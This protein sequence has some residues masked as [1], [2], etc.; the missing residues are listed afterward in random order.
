METTDTS[1][2]LLLAAFAGSILTFLLLL[3]VIYAI[4]L[5]KVF[6]KAG[7]EG[8]K[9]FIPVYNVYVLQTITFGSAKSLFFLCMFVPYLNGVYG[10]YLLFNF[11]RAY[12]LSDGGAI[13]YMFFSPIMNFYLA[14]SNSVQYK[15]VQPFIIK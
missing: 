5:W 13:A 1:S 11:A 12:G 14:F 3:H 9:A 10:L 2:E 15:G 8:W 6:T 7:Q 4:A